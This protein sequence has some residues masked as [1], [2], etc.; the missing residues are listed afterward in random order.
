MNK[1]LIYS[2]FHAN[3]NGKALI[4]ML[5]LYKQKKEHPFWNGE[6]IWHCTVFNI[7]F[8]K[9]K[10]AAVFFKNKKE[11]KRQRNFR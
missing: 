7:F 1:I 10:F 11:P 6:E 5:K 9:K 3:H 2:E 4:T 8:L